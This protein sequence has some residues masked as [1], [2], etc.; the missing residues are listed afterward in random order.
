MAIVTISRLYGSGGSDV[1][2]RVAE[3]LGW[4]LL[5]NALIDEVAARLGVSPEQVTLREERVDV[6]RRPVDRPVTDADRQFQER[7]IEA[8]ETAEEAVVSKE[9]RVTEELVVRKEVDE[10]TQTVSDTVR[11]T[12]VEVEDERTK[13]MTGTTGN[14]DDRT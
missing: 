9:A 2:A 1:A 10:R 13:R 4:S 3:L 12:E 14:P 8:T 6:E 5:D 11:S 7:T